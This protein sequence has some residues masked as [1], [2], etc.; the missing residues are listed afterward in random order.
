MKIDLKK[1][2]V[3]E[4]AAFFWFRK[5]RASILF[6]KTAGCRRPLLRAL[7]KCLP[8]SRVRRSCEHDPLV[9]C[10]VEKFFTNL[11]NVIFST[12]TQ[13]HGVSSPR[14]NNKIH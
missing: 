9:P 13:V 14:L 10:K 4:W 1:Q 12:V 7:T 2:I 5:Y 8:C 11:P 6:G 3:K